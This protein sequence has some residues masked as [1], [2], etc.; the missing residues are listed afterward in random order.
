MKFD[1]FRRAVQFVIILGLL[2]GQYQPGTAQAAGASL[3]FTPSVGTYVIGDKFTIS[4]KAFVG[5]ANINAAEGLI[6]FDRNYLEVAGV[7]DAGSI[8]SLWTT[9]PSFSNSAGTISF[10]G[11]IQA[12]GFSG[13]Q[14]KVM[15]ITFRAKAVGS[16]LVRFSSGAILSNDGKG[17]N[18]LE[19]MG[20]ANFTIAA[21]ETVAAAAESAASSTAAASAK[22]AGAVTNIE[23]IDSLDTEATDEYIKPYIASVTNPDQNAW[24]NNNDI[25][26]QW[27]VP[28]NATGLSWALT[29][30]FKTDPESKP[31]ALIG[32]KAFENV[33]DGMWFFHLKFY[34]GKKWGTV[35][36]FRLLVDTSRPSPLV[37]TVRQNDANSL[38]K[39]LFKTTDNT[40]GVDHY[41][42]FVNSFEDKEFSLPEDQAQDQLAVQLTNLEYGKHT[43]LIKVV[44]KAGNETVST[45]EFEVQPI[46]APVIKN[47]AKEIKVS[48]QFF[49]SGTSLPEVAI[50][51]Y[52]QSEGNKVTS[53]AVRSDVNGNWFYLGE[54]KLPN[55]RYVV[56]VEAENSLGLKSMPSEK[57]S[58]L[59]TPPVFAVIG[60]FVINYFTVLVSL[61]FMIILIAILLYF[62][63]NMIR[64]RLKKETVE[65]EVVLQQNLA[66]LK[67]IV[68]DEVA[69][70][71]KLAPQPAAVKE[72]KKMKDAF[73]QQIDQARKKIMKEIKDVEAI[74]K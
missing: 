38:P 43:A 51:V 47:Y 16:G 26:L 25:Q 52:I 54:P 50:N 59:V 4:V 67:K 20:S 35:G 64:K 32:N 49:V 1:L 68:D 42:V 33:E 30:D 58:F 3:F 17:S 46:E 73:G 31:Q 18:I 48:D 36:R 39:L 72:G 6:A 7:S 53:A 2:F 12:P 10:G 19:S 28:K 9:Q 65:V 55:G 66:N 41:E 69:K 40:S 70:L 44:D 45:T 22:K 5:G 74:L 8:F 63:I 29:R 34:D 62:I 11:G 61:L 23:P 56:W 24:S 15:S 14:G 71:S 27:E 21:K 37:I 57:V 60:N 13:Q